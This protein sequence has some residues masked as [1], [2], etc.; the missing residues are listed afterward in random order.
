MSDFLK[1]RHL[2]TDTKHKIGLKAKGNNRAKGKR[3]DE[4]RKR[5]S[6]AQKTSFKCRKFLAEHNEKQGTRIV[7]MNID[8][9]VI[10]TYKSI[11]VASKE[12]GIHRS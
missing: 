11:R 3:S 2:S 8:G 4:S 1:G 12:T 10:K 5:M 6:I 9:V 7:Q